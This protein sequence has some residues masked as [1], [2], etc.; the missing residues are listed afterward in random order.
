MYNHVE[1]VGIHQPYDP[2][3][4]GH[5]LTHSFHPCVLEKNTASK[6]AACSGCGMGWYLK[7]L[8]CK[9]LGTNQGGIV[10]THVMNHV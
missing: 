4:G 3:F 7:N 2:I 8:A 9:I 10:A 6:L 5:S 1:L